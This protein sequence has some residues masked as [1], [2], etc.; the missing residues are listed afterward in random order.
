MDI[1]AELTSQISDLSDEEW[2]LLEDD[3]HVQEVE[4]GAAGVEYLVERVRRV[5]RVAASRRQARNEAGATVNPA[6]LARRASSRADAISALLAADASRREEVV[7]FRREVLRGK[8][9]KPER[10]AEWIERRSREGEQVRRKVLGEPWE[11]DPRA[12]GREW[13]DG[14]PVVRYETP[15]VEYAAPEGGWVQRA[16]S[17]S[18]LERL[19]KVGEGLASRYGWQPAQATI[20]LLTGAVPI[21]PAI[22]ARTVSKLPVVAATRIV[23]EVDPTATPREVAEHY[24]EVRTRVTG[25]Q[26]SRRMS[27]KHLRLAIFA[28]S[29]DQGAWADR[30]A[31]W[32]SDFPDWRYTEPTNFQRDATSAISRLLRPPFDL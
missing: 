11:V 7:A 12:E 9:L 28:E 17:S 19:R 27:E 26:R 6:E 1:R 5:R 4:S 32:N 25:G 21:L 29:H 8:L 2:G 18:E 20:F 16:A 22:R 10:V 23:L 14:R 15:S 31:R 30:M 3:G 13:I 24:A